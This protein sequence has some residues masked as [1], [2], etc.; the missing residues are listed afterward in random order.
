[1][2]SCE[3]LQCTTLEATMGLHS[4]GSLCEG[5]IHVRVDQGFRSPIIGFPRNVDGSNKDSKSGITSEAI[6]Q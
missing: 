6:L 3:P 5:R 2:S 1:M 4:P